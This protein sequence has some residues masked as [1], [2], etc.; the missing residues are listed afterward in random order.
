MNRQTLARRE[1]VL[2]AEHP[3]TLTSMYFLAH[4]LASRHRYREF[5]AL[6][7]ERVLDTIPLSERS[8]QLLVHA[9]DTMRR[10]R[11]TSL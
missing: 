5:I 9:T 10:I 8:I 3:S 7:N 2:G 1:K 11:L 4:V 6:Y